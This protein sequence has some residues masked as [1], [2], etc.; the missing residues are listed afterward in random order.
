M[1]KHSIED[2][3][4]HLGAKVP[5]RGSGWRK[6]LC[7]FHE[8]RTASAAVN[9]DINRFKCHGCGV[10]GDTYDLIQLK[11]GG[12]LIEAIEFASTI[13]TSGDGA[14]RKPYRPSTGVSVNKASLGRRGSQV[15]LGRGRRS[16]SGT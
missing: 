13:S 16:T 11:N 12:T 3:L 5:A 1:D 7:P 14:V 6:M 15:S 2:Y 9:F 10:S 4:N 8:D